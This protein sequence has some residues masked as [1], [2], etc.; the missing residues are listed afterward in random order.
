MG[1]QGEAWFVCFQAG[2]CGWLKLRYVDPGEIGLC[3]GN[4]WHL[5]NGSHRCSDW[6]S[7]F[8]FSRAPGIA[9]W[10]PPVAVTAAHCTCPRG[11]GHPSHCFSRHPNGAMPTGFR[12]GLRHVPAVRLWSS[13]LATQTEPHVPICATGML[14]PAE[15]SG[16]AGN[17]ECPHV[18]PSTPYDKVCAGGQ[19]S[20]KP[21]RWI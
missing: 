15:G 12:P 17:R 21:K 2:W 13:P 7:K 6:K 1:A 10:S 16:G 11:S 9:G 18:K 8:L 3:L 4:A 5:I 19:G 14:M 20:F